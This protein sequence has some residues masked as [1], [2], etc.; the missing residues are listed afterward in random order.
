MIVCQSTSKSASLDCFKLR[1]EKKLR[2]KQG[3]SAVKLG[4]LHQP[5]ETNHERKILT[6]PDLSASPLKADQAH[7]RIMNKTLGI[8]VF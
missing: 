4:S 1:P 3:T 6:S 5:G 8:C 7:V 2:G